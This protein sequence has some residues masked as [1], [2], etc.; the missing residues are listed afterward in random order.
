MKFKLASAALCAAFLAGSS[1]SFAQDDSEAVK[2]NTYPLAAPAGV[3]SHADKIAP[4]GS[5][6][7]GP[8]NDKTWIRGHAWDPPPGAK[9][10]NPVKA[11]LLAGGK[12]TS[13]TANG[14][15]DPAVY[16]AAAN[17]GVDFIWTEMQ[18]SGGTWD[19]VQKMW[20]ACPH[21]KAVPGVRVANA[22]EFDEQ[23]ALDL[24]AMVLVIPTVRNIEE[25]KEAVKWAYYPPMG[26][27]SRGSMTPA[28]RNVPG[29]Y[30]NTANDNIVLIL[31][32]ETMDGLRDADKIAALPG[33]DAVF[34]ASG[35]LGN[36]S[37]YK[38]GDPDYEREINIVHDAALRA[39][40]VL[41]GP[42]TWVNR[43]DFTCF[44]G[45]GDTSGAPGPGGD[46]QAF[47]NNRSKKMLGPLWN[48]QGKVEVGPYAEG[49]VEKPAKGGG[50]E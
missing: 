3:D 21:A 40:K 11:K 12:I 6:N 4:P 42:Y 19:S 2:A 34:A 50:G 14:N 48:T 22:N 49:Y 38:A 26:Q 39:H 25:A 47:F 17:S 24:G 32:I 7:T 10:W 9:I 27:R 15:D 29:G 8:Y 31:M 13:V 5:V 44:Q 36:F 20:N 33:V 23:H 30:R 37:G 18:H 16:C 28:L 46:I 1:F 45:P 41:C 43:P 35:D